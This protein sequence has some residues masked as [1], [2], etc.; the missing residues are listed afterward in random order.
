[1]DGA[2]ALFRELLARS[3]E[4][5]GKILQLREPVSHWQNGLGVVDVHAGTKLQRRQC[6][7]E[8]VDQSERRGIW[9]QMAPPSLSVLSLAH[10]RLLGHSPLFWTPP[11]P[12][13][14]RVSE[15]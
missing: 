2:A 8:H 7:R 4:L 11:G 14:D 5:S 1:M 15:P 12:P 6:G 13:R 9:D 3:A 10:P